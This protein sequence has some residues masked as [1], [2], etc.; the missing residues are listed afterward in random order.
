MHSFSLLCR[1]FRQESL[2]SLHLFRPFFWS[3]F[4][5]MDCCSSCGRAPCNTADDSRRIATALSVCLSC[6]GVR[7]SVSFLPVGLRCRIH[8]TC[9]PCR[10]QVEFCVR[11]LPFYISLDSVALYLLYYSEWS[12]P[13]SSLYPSTVAWR[14]SE[15]RN[16]NSVKDSCF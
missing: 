1:H 12:T 8:K 2:W 5:T 6:F 9:P 3:S 16:Q 7:L 15:G 11:R 4:H 14:W 13:F 10:H